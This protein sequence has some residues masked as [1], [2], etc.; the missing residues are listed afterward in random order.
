MVLLLDINFIVSMYLHMYKKAQKN[1]VSFAFQATIL[2]LLIYSLWIVGSTMIYQ[3]LI[4]IQKKKV[5]KNEQEGL[6]GSHLRIV[7]Q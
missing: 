6:W 2:G 7:M 4:A 3:V 1:S 5:K